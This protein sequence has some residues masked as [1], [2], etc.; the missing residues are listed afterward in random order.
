MAQTV[1]AFLDPNMRRIAYWVLLAGTVVV[2]VALSRPHTSFDKVP[3]NKAMQDWL[4]HPHIEDGAVIV[5]W[6]PEQLHAVKYWLIL[7]YLFALVYTAFF[8]LLC[9]LLSTRASGVLSAVGAL[10]S[11]AVLLG[12]FFDIG[13]NTVLWLLLN[14]GR[15]Q[16]ILD[17]LRWLSQLKWLMPVLTFIYLFVWMGF[18]MEK[19]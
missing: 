10:L 8:S 4:T 14:G 3:I 17:P 1:F 2:A 15:N 13:E 18:Q 9:S 19:E 7:D 5:P 16:N 6:S 11:W 12:A